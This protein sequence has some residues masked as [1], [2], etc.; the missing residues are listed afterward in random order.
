MGDER[1]DKPRAGTTRTPIQPAAGKPR[2][3]APTKPT[4][5]STAQVSRAPAAVSRAPAAVSR[6][7]APTAQRPLVKAGKTSAVDK[8]TQTVTRLQAAVAQ[9]AEEGRNVSA[10]GLR[11]A[12]AV[13]GSLNALIRAT[14]RYRKGAEKFAIEEEGGANATQQAVADRVARAW[15]KAK[16]APL[17]V[18]ALCVKIDGDEALRADHEHSQWVLFAFMA[19]VRKIAPKRVMTASDVLRLVQALVA[20]EPRLESIERFRD[21]IDADGAEGFAVSVHTSF[22]EVLE[23][24][25]LEEEREFTKAFAMARFEV[26]RAG[27]AVYIAARDLDQVAMR[28][29]F[30]VP[31][32]MYAATDFSTALG[33]L[34]DEML[35]QI[36]KRCDD[37]NGWAT[38]EIEAVLALPEL[39]SAITPEHMAR[40]VVTRLSDEADEQFLMLLTRLNV[41][42]DPFRQA[43]AAALGTREVGEIIARQLDLSAQTLEALGRFLALSP[44][45]LAQ[46]VVAGMLD[47]ATDESEA[48]TALTTLLDDFGAAQLCEWV[49][50]GQLVEESAALLSLVVGEHAPPAGELNRLALGVTAPVSI[51]LLSPL[52]SPVLHELGRTLRVLW[53][54]ASEKETD[55]LIE[56][57]ARGAAKENLK[58]LGDLLG[59][60][61]ADVLKGRTQYALCA[62]L[63][64]HGLGRTHVLPLALQRGA[65][66]Q[67]RLVALDCLKVNAEL[68]KEATRFRLSTFLESSE[69][70]ERL[71]QLASAARS[72]R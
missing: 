5:P 3:G 23:E 54:R 61:K 52:P 71:K 38:A 37:A 72:A 29:E 59:E 39:R 8:V 65:K 44:E 12:R 56:L 64:E 21:W 57:M 4:R 46:A 26:P 69:V 25:D 17:E 50:S 34:S 42:N 36:G 16:L 10:E 2:A 9:L 11:P 14:A 28:R 48:I 67:L 13:G 18:E 45:P 6:A 19:G 47:R 66:E 40:R 20:L 27:D 58:L 31:I 41:K 30:E 49:P 70:R 1:R 60:G 43:V 68:A 53:G 63:I 51:A 55:V 7:P 24:V 15:R 22:R 32:E 35:A 33:G 62:A